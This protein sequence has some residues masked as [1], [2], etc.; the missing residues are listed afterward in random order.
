SSWLMLAR[1][2]DLC[3]LANCSWR[4]LSW[5]SSNGR[6]FSMAITAWSAKV[7]SSSICLSV[8]GATS[9]FH[10]PIVPSGTPS[11]SKGIANGHPSA[12]GFPGNHIPG[13][14]GSLEFALHGARAARDLSQ[15]PAL[16]GLGAL[17]QLQGTGRGIVGSG[18]TAAFAI[19]AENHAVLG[20]ANAD[21]ILQ[22]RPKDALEV[23]RCPA[24]GLEHLGRGSLLPPRFAQLLR[25]RLPLVEQPPIPDRDHRLVGE[26]LDQ[27]DLLVGKRPHGF[28]YYLEHTNR[29]PLA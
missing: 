4:F 27:L 8:N 18:G 19:V 14:P 21:G 16:R 23:E 5:I 6:T 9:V 1:N 25:A 26:G 20:T 24:D 29:I 7:V 15:F 2:C 28:A 11:R 3:S 10:R 12:F 17:P 13:L 22:Q